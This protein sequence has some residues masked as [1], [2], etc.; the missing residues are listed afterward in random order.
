MRSALLANGLAKLAPGV[1][2]GF[3]V[4]PGSFAAPAPDKG[5][6]A[7]LRVGGD[8]GGSEM[9]SRSSSSEDE[10]SKRD[11]LPLPLGDRCRCSDEAL[12]E[13]PLTEVEDERADRG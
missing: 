12:D 5:A 1:R 2:F 8:E 9:S 13:I 3:G 4:L 10:R 7:P 6:R 11:P